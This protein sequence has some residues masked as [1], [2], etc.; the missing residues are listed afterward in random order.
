MGRDGGENGTVDDFSHLSMA[1]WDDLVLA[2]PGTWEMQ[3]PEQ[4]KRCIL[5]TMQ[6]F[7]KVQTRI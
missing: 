1:D 3:G 6:D 7:V 4:I 2:F 5:S